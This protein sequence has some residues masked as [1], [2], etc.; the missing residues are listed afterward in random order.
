MREASVSIE[1]L[2]TL[3]ALNTKISTEY[4][5]L[6]SLLTSIMEAAMCMVECDSVS[7]MLLNNEDGKLHFSIALG[8]K[9]A[10]V[11]KII[12][13]SKS[14]AGWV[15]QNK[16][17]VI[18]NDVA[19]DP[20]FNS[21]V[22]EKTQYITRNM[23]AFPM[24]AAGECIGVI[25][26]LNKAEGR[27]FSEN[28]LSVLRLFG[29]QAGS[30]YENANVFI[31][32]KQQLNVLQ[33]VISAGPEYHSFVAQNPK[34]LKILEDV[35]IIAKTNSSV[36]IYGESGVGKE[37]FAEQVQLRSNRRDKPFVRVSCAALS[38]SLLESELFGHVKGAYTNATSNQKGRFEMADGGTIFLDE[39]GELPLDLQAKLLRVI[40]ERKFERVG[41][42]E[43]I[44]VDVR[45]IAATNRNLEEM[46]SQKL[47]RND[48]Y[49]RLNVMPI[50]I[51]PLRE[52]KEDIEPLCRLFMEK[53]GM[54]TNKKFSGFSSAALKA[55]YNYSWPGNIRELENTIERACILGQ[56]P[57]IGV[58]DLHIPHG[59]DV[60]LEENVL[61]EDSVETASFNSDRTLKTAINGFKKEYVTKILSEVNWNQTKAAKIL[62]LQR[63][64][65]NKLLTELDIKRG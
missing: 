40:Q 14:I 29:S 36:L 13:D 34:V 64:Y 58:D 20:R 12:V 38:P 6:N 51:P 21:T 3:I 7:L 45:I 26:V 23:I 46:V 60:S 37:L 63:T 33:K 65:V 48:L 55:M 56:P 49:F 52:R 4:S 54:E 59:E 1:K 41:S 25:E 39:I 50:T 22:Q 10:E 19:N 57:L 30:A 32:N 28:D 35:D 62:G 5:D 42:S 27:D 47:F 2:K 44:S 43:T 16:Q 24:I 9:G 17:A 18:I 8:P 53:F 61:F 11:K 31:Q 15:C